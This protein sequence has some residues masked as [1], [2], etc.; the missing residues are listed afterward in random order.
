M[1]KQ[2]IISLLFFISMFFLPVAALE[3]LTNQ[4]D[5]LAGHWAEQHIV[6]WV[7]EGLAHGYADSTFRPDHPVSRAEFIA[8]A[9]RSFGIPPASLNAM[10]SD[11]P[12]TAWF[13][14]EISS[15]VNAGIISGYPDGTF[16]PERSITRQEAAQVLAKRLQLPLIKETNAFIDAQNIA[17]WAHNSVNAIT[18]A[19][20]MVGYPNGTFAPQQPI[21]RAET[22]VILSRAL[23]YARDSVPVQSIFTKPGSYGPESGMQII[24]EDVFIKSGGFSLQNTLIRGNL[25]ICQDIMAGDVTL[26]HVSVEGDTYVRGGRNIFFMGGSYGDIFIEQAGAKVRIVTANVEGIDVTITEEFEGSEIILEGLYHLV[27][28]K[29]ANVA[30]Y[31]PNEDCHVHNLIL[32]ES[33]FSAYIAGK[34]S[35]YKVM[36]KSEDAVLEIIPEKTNLED[37]SDENI[38][39]ELRSNELPPESL[40]TRPATP[41]LQVTDFHIDN[42]DISGSAHTWHLGESLQSPGEDIGGLTITFNQDIHKDGY[43]SFEIRAYDRAGKKLNL[44]SEDFV[45]SFLFGSFSGGNTNQLQG[46]LNHNYSTF[47]ALM[48]STV[49]GEVHRLEFDIYNLKRDRSLTVALVINAPAS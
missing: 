27:T 48:D 35:I 37:E 31:I 49:K 12:E 32:E 23:A 42:I 43:E 4:P 19:G 18:N 6:Q 1:N 36:I 10:F 34:G 26:V 25:N 41:P 2:G 17:A 21:S 33:A 22:V 8:F 9:N 29:G 14:R 3:A 46:R 20:I 44:V 5:D 28:I 15:A 24:E 39:G 30:L 7:N 45:R 11:V 40:P 47:Y 13:F 16:R 38:E